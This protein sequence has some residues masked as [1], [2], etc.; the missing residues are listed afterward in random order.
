MDK[1]AKAFDRGNTEA[2]LGGDEDH[3]SGKGWGSCGPDG[4]GGVK[5]N[6]GDGSLGEEGNEFALAHDA[7]KGVEG[8]EFK[9]CVEGLALALELFLE[10]PLHAVAVLKDNVGRFD[11]FLPGDLAVAGEGMLG[12]H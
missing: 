9:D 10:E 7:S 5:V 12:V 1:V 4:E 2:I 3:F 11:D 8:V 6:V